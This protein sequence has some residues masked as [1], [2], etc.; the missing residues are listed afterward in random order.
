[1]WEAVS[2]NWQ[3]VVAVVVVVVVVGSAGSEAV[4]LRDAE[5]DSR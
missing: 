1:M 5:K 2:G 3:T 4:E